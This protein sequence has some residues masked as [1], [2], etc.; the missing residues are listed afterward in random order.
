MQVV[1]ASL[2]LHREGELQCEG[3]DLAELPSILEKTKSNQYAYTEKPIF[4]QSRPYSKRVQW[5]LT[6]ETKQEILA[7]EV[8]H[9]QGC[10]DAAFDFLRGP[11]NSAPRTMPP[12]FGFPHCF[13]DMALWNEWAAQRQ[14][15]HCGADFT[16][17]QRA[18]IHNLI[19]EAGRN[20]S[21][22]D[23]VESELLSPRNILSKEYVAQ[24]GPLLMKPLS[25]LS[26]FILD[27]A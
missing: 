5:P 18:E 6:E 7:L 10:A 2:Q 3:V 12:V 11:G 14:A 19:V 21:R 15:Q 1:C 27:R 24:F 22:K 4:N 20:I 25:K 9:D 23:P 8:S 17:D 13:R 16:L 26:P